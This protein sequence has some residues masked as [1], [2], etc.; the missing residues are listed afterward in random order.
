[1]GTKNTSPQDAREEVTIGVMMPLVG[2]FGAVGEGIKNAALMAAEE[3]MKS[4]PTVNIVTP[5][6]DDRFDTK[7]GIAAFTK[8][9]SIDEID[10]LLMVSTPIIDAYY[11]NMRTVGIPIASVGL[12]NNGIGDDN[13]FQLTAEPKVQTAKF[14]KSINEFGYTK[15]AI[16]HEN[17]LPASISFYGA[18]L[19]N[20]TGAHEDFLI[21]DV[22][23]ARTLA[24]KIQAAE[25]D[26]IVFLN[27][28]TLGA[29]L[30]KE[31]LAQKITPTEVA[32]YYDA[33]LQ[34]GQSEYEKMLGS[35]NVLDGAFVLQ[36]LTPDISAF[37]EK[38]EARYGVAPTPFAEYGYDGMITLLETRA[39]DSA[40]WVENLKV[41][42]MD[43]YTGPMKFDSV[44]IRIQETDVWVLKGG[45]AVE[46]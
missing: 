21:T 15:L 28:P 19:E 26:A 34:T 22:N 5:I 46:K 35:I 4:N 30:T 20:Y 9:T 8:L 14:A 33:Q 3:Y 16:V 23:E 31:L 11:E 39:D 27:T 10:A 1:M 24:M 38:Y 42:D 36:Y 18:F 41:L 29:A 12:Q 45:V 2:D 7:V 32:F 37:K 44:G 43:S 25:V 17:A 6:E 13:I 40:T